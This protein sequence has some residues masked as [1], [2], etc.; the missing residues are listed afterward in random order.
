MS[1]TIYGNPVGTPLSPKKIEEVL[2]P[3]KTVNGKAPD[4]NG[5]VNISESFSVRDF[6]ATGNGSTD[7]STAIQ[8][9]LDTCRA[10]GGGVVR[11]PHGIYVLGRAVKFYSGQHLIGEPGTV[12]LQQDGDTGFNYGNLM[13]NFYDGSGGYDATHDVVIE[14]LIFDGGDQTDSPSTL[15]A[16][17]HSRNVIIRNCTFRNG[18]SGGEVGNGH[19]IEIN[20]SYGVTIDLCFFVNNRRTGYMSEIIQTDSAYSGAA[21]PWEPDIG[22]RADDST[23][24]ENI[25]IS[26]C[27]F[28]GVLRE[29]AID[30]NCFIGGHSVDV[31]KGVTV[32]CCTFVNGGYAIKYDSVEGLVVR[33]NTM[34]DVLVGVFVQPGTDTMVTGN[35]A[36]GTTQGIYPKSRTTGTGNMVNGEIYEDPPASKVIE[37]DIADFEDDM[38]SLLNSLTE[39]GTYRF[40]D[41]GFTQTVTVYRTGSAV[42]HIRQSEEEYQEIFF[43][44]GYITDGAIEWDGRTESMIMDQGRA[45]ELFSDKNHGHM[46]YKNTTLSIREY[47][48]QL[49]QSTA[50]SCEQ[51]VNKQYHI[52][53]I[54]S[55]SSPS[56]NFNFCQ[57]YYDILNPSKIYKRSMSTNRNGAVLSEGSW[58]VFE[59]VEVTE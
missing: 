29:V 22:D 11:F 25:R 27:L 13:R 2:N 36:S 45:F 3:V 50:S 26:R 9:A 18:F 38:E 12:L 42:M 16:M 34:Q 20:S 47:L 32:E 53:Q 49:P 17:C 5:N 43:R 59:G 46:E 21:Y 6:G 10:A 7:D 41:C 31:S 39:P 23:I 8:E 15:L 33:N 30:R 52:R 51:L 28:N 37:L 35:V 14:N 57:E 55:P 56:T 1:S 54:Y 40:S 44:G 24:P 19:D 58:Y 4:E 48:T